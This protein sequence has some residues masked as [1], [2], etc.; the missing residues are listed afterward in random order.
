MKLKWKASKALSYDLTHDR[1]IYDKIGGDITAA[2]WGDGGWINMSFM[3][4]YSNICKYIL[5]FFKSNK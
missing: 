2:R 5:R 4:F 3:G 1:P